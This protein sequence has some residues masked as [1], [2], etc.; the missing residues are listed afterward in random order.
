L[1]RDAAPGRDGQPWA[2]DGEALEANRRD[3]SDRLK[4]GAD[5]AQPVERVDMPTPDGRPRPLGR[6][7]L[8]DQIVQRATVAGRNAIDA[9][10]VLGVSSGVRPGR[11]PHHALDAV[12]V[13]IATRSSHGGLEADIRGVCEARDHAWLRK[14]VAP[15]MGDRRGVRHLRQG[16]QAGVL[17]EGPW[18]APA[19]GTPPGGRVSP[20]AAKISRHDV[21]D[22]WADRWRRRSA[23]GAGIIVRAA[24]D[25]LVGVEHRDAAERCWGALRERVQPC[26]RER[27]PEQ[28]RLLAWGRDAADRRQRRGQGTPETFDVLGVTH[29]GRQTRRGQCTVRR[30]TIATR[31]RTTRPEV[32]ATLRP[33][34]PWPIPPP[35]AW[36]SSVRLGHSRDD[37]GPRH[38]SVLTGFRETVRRDWCRTLRRRRQRSRLTWPRMDALADRW[39]PTPR[40]GPPYPAPRL[41]V[42][43]RGRSPGRSCRTPGSVRGA[44]G[45]WRPYRD[46]RG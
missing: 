13:G 12:T 3:L 22:R 31:L 37:G 30:K 43:P 35:G 46:R 4:R 7:T 21:L 41:C 28:T 39:R 23:R 2:A 33:R 32:Q 38:G 24:D 26:N 15:R 20:L 29:R 17:E 36:L 19:D 27:P 1:N 10:D 11:R 6:P 25:C 42:M 8:E 40:L 5:P 18:H 34:R 14:L 44:S 45:H 9:G 16:L